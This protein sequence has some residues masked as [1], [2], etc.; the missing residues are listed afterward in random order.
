MIDTFCLHKG[1]DSVFRVVKL[2]IIALIGGCILAGFLLMVHSITD[3]EAY[4]L[5]FNVDYI[6]V[7]SHIWS[8]PEIG[9]VFHFVFCIISVVVLYY[10]LIYWN[11]EH[12]GII[13]IAVYTFGSAVLFF[14]TGFSELLPEAGDF[15]AWIYWT[16][17]HFL[18]G[19]FIGMFVKRWA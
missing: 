11:L 16:S 14:L 15:S 7:L 19:A 13:Y 6:P 5:L 8:Q 4:I 1:G 10:L 9:I 2:T 17:A 3:N 12:K 18:Y